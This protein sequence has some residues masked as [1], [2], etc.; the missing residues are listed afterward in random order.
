MLRSK[1]Q[2]YYLLLE[3]LLFLLL[4]GCASYV[5]VSQHREE[6]RKNAQPVDGDPTSHLPLEIPRSHDTTLRVHYRQAF[7]YGFSPHYKQSLWVA[8]QFLSSELT[9]RVG[10]SNRFTPDP[11]ESESATNE[12]Y[13]RSGFDKGHLAPAADMHWNPEAMRQSFYFTNISPQLPALNRGGWKY[14]E[15]QVREWTRRYDTLYVVTGPLF[16]KTLTYIGKNQIPVPSHFYKA[17]LTRFDGRWESIAFI[18]ENKKDFISLSDVRCTVDSL[19]GLSGLDF[20]S[21]LDD[22]VEKLVESH[23]HANFWFLSHPNGK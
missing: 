11:Y 4:V 13:K 15:N 21:R 1:R 19:E 9:K 6:H 12:D 22:S 7:S 3:S 14:L 18:M 2:F 8:Y 20:F 5:Q 16:L 17:L 23:Y 10:R